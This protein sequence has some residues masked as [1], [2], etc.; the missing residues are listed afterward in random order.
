MKPSLLGCVFALSVASF[1]LASK[2]DVY[3]TGDSLVGF[4]A[5]D[6][7]GE[8]VTFKAGDAKFILFDTPGESG[9]S[10]QPKDPD[11]FAKNRAL[12]VVNISEL[13]MIK[14]KIA[15]SRMKAKPFRMVVLD[16]KDKAERFPLQKGKFTVLMLDDKGSITDVKFAAPGRELQELVTG[17]KS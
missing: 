11:W 5:P 4:S 6:Q 7:H 8:T 15:R 17:G 3:R 13:S 9:E 16:E 2:A 1:S 14:R 10:Q 12:L